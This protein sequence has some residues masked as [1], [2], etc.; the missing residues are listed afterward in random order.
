MDEID[1]AQERDEFFRELALSQRRGGVTPP[2]TTATHCFECG[3]EIPEGRR[4]AVPGA[5]LCV[6]CQEAREIHSH[7]RTL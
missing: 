4:R 6:S 1:R 7:W 5:R 3:E 2:E